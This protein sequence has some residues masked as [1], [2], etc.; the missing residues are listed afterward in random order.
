MVASHAVDSGVNVRHA[1]Q[2]KSRIA[3]HVVVYIPERSLGLAPGANS[4]DGGGRLRGFGEGR[5]LPHSDF[6][7]V[8]GGYSGAAH[9]GQYATHGACAAKEPAWGHLLGG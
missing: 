8:T 9:A 6:I 1:K 2:G 4:D 7:V 5:T 3:P